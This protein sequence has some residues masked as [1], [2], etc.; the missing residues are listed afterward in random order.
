[1]VYRNVV[2]TELKIEPIPTVYSHIQEKGVY[3]KVGEATEVALKVLAEKL[4][5]Q[6]VEKA[7]LSP[8][9]KATACLKA[10]ETKYEKV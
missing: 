2:C 8:S 6:A 5:V 9:Q 10:I 4:N 1:M 7:S 3:E